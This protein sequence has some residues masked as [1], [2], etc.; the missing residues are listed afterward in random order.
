LGPD[1]EVF[2]KPMYGNAIV[3]IQSRLQLARQALLDLLSECEQLL[4]LERAA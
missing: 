1:G 3:D 4:G 2:A